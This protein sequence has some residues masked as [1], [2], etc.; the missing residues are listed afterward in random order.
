[1]N[2]LQVGEKGNRFISLNLR[3]MELQETSCHSLEATRIDDMFDSAFEKN[4]FM[5]NFLFH[6]MTPMTTLSVNMY[7]DTKN[8]LTVVINTPETLKVVAE[9]FLEAFLWL[10]VENVSKKKVG[11]KEEKKNGEEERK[12][13]NTVVSFHE[14]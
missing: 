3:G 12:G 11:R 1:M 10:V 7:S 13:D 5:N 8:V 2:I 14:G 9:S 4:A 6:T